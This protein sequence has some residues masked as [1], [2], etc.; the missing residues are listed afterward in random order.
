MGK[1]SVD[2]IKN[3]EFFG[4]INWEEIYAKKISPPIKPNIKNLLENK[5]FPEFNEPSE[6][7]E[8]K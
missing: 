8:T 4:N 7:L 6:S 2:E 1:N 3:H 5:N